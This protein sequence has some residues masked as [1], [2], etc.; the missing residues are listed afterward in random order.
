MEDSPGAFLFSFSAFAT[1]QVNVH[2]DPLIVIVLM[3]K[4]EGHIE[5]EEPVII[6]TLKPYV[7]AGIDAYFIF[8]TGSTDNTIVLYIG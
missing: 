6:E 8:D 5:R 7:D 1:Q 4:D 3:V 2:F